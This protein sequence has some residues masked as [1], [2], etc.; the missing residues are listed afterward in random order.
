M[1]TIDIITG[2]NTYLKTENKSIIEELL[3]KLDV[4]Y[5][6]EEMKARGG[7]AA[8]KRLRIA[9]KILKQNKKDEI[10]TALHKCFTEEIDGE[11]YQIFGC[12][13]YFVALKEKYKTTAE[14]HTPEEQKELG[15]NMGRFFDDLKNAIFNKVDFDITEI[16]KDFENFKSEEKLWPKNVR[17]G[18]CILPIG[19]I[20]SMGFD[21]EYFINIIEVLGPNTEFYQNE[22][23]NGTSC[24]K[25]D[26]GMAL[27][28]PCRLKNEVA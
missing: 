18:R 3:N 25:S 28:C 9:N 17:R 6:E 14:E 20:D 10:L 22:K 8:L 4:Q 11:T 5:R 23:P 27:L 13:Y 24:F 12:Q 16:K 15:Y 26:I 19:N 21:A 1:K 7:N 2:L